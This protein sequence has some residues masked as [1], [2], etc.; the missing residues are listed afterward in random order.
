MEPN[1]RLGNLVVGIK[2]KKFNID[3]IV[4]VQHK[5]LGKIIKRVKSIDENGIELQSDNKKYGSIA[6]NEIH[7]PESIIGKVFFKI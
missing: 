2:S 1:Y 6:V 5:S 7:S 4:I 3:D